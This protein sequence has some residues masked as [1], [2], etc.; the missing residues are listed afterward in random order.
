MNIIKFKRLGF[1]AGM[2]FLV[3]IACW[4]TASC[5]LGKSSF[6]GKPL[7]NPDSIFVNEEIEVRF[8]QSIMANSNLDNTS[9][10][11]T[12][13]AGSALAEPA[14]M[15]DDG[16]MD[17]GDDIMGDGV[18][19]CIANLNASAEGTQDF[20]VV[21]T[22]VATTKKSSRSVHSQTTSILAITHLTTEQVNNALD[23]ANGAQAKFDDELGKNGGDTAA[24]IA[25]TLADLNANPKVS[26]AG[27]SENNAGVWWVNTDGTLGGMSGNTS[28]D[29]FSK[30]RQRQNASRSDCSA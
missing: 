8:T 3:I 21:A 10:M 15:Y 4:A 26:Q 5:K 12:Q 13:V 27:A 23:I 19:S 29:T 6:L 17:H 18:Y 16:N 7:A 2:C 9:I 14:Q 28:A 11:L 20:Q 22:T 25:A 1:S 30:V 24:A